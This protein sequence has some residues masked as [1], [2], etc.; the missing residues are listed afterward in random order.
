MHGYASSNPFGLDDVRNDHL[1]EASHLLYT[2]GNGNK[3][4]RKSLD[5]INDLRM[6]VGLRGLAPLRSHDWVC[7]FSLF[8]YVLTTFFSLLFSMF[9]GY[10]LAFKC[11]RSSHMIIRYQTWEGSLM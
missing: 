11:R 5:E 2:P 8:S 3:M 9:E 6:M 10:L 4:K 1:L 7:V